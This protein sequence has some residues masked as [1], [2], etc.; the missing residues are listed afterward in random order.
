M[1]DR[2]E[3]GTYLCAAAATGGEVRLTGTSAAYVSMP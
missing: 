1:P 3:T 2:I